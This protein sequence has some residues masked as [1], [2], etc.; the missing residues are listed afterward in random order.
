M[1]DT[2]GRSPAFDTAVPNVARMYDFMLGGKD[3]YASDRDAVGMLLEMAPEAPLRA[4]L[5]RAFLGRAVRYVAGQGVRQFLDVGAGLP[6]QE[7]V[8]QAARA[9]ALDARTVYVD[10][11]PVVLTHGRALLAADPQTAVVAGDVREAAGILGD[12]RTRELL[13]FTRPI[14]IL[15]VAILHFVPDS[16]GPAGIVAAFRDAIAPGSYLILSHA[17]M[18]GAPS[19]EAARTSDAEAVYDRATAPLIMRD[20]GQVSQLLEGFSLVEPGLVHVTA[21]RPDGPSRGGFD[22]FLGAVGRKD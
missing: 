18:D 19:R 22:A 2:A 6:T 16:D 10:N 20:T 4:R 14:C 7:N 3:N 11:D 12:P 1:P 13:D 9:V 17:T 21:W 8:H 15:L 5:N